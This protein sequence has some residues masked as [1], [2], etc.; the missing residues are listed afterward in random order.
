MMHAQNVGIGT[1]NPVATLDVNGSIKSGSSSTSSLAIT[2]G[3][4]QSDFIIKS[5]PDGLVGFRKGH[6]ALA[7]NYIIAFE[8]TFPT[9]N[10]PQIEGPMIGEIKIFTGYYE[11]YGWLFCHG[12]LLMIT[13]YQG[14]FTLLGTTY[15][16]DGQ[17][18]FALPDLRGAVPVG[19]GSG[20]S[21]GEP[22]N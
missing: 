1:S 14:L 8:G 9:Q 3:G 5:S 12:Q 4:N 20:W 16:G 2:T 22:S 21:L 7:L 13:Q 6:V 18:T 19:E 17:S 11:P 15:G 10:S